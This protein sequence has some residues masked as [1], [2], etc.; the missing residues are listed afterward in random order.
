[1]T[2]DL[3]VA[4]PLDASAMA[5]AHVDSIRSLG[6]ASYPP[7]VV[8]AWAEAVRPQMY[9]EAIGSGER[10][11]VAFDPVDPRACAGFSSHRIDDGV[12]GVSV[13][14]RGRFA[15]RG[16]GTGLLEQA[17]AS[18]RSAGATS[19]AID[20][21]LAAESFYRARGFVETGRGE[22]RLPSGVTMACVFM[23]REL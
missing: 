17:L 4:M 6:P 1:M 20:A 12:H 8:D 3:R 9:D 19:V 23:R 2:F 7:P 16:L 10:F 15:R 14:V 21:S 11:W 13:Y 5:D 22:H 18:A